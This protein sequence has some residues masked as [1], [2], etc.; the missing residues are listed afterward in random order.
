MGINGISL[1]IWNP[2]YYNK[3]I[4]TT[5]NSITF[6]KFKYPFLYNSS[7]LDEYIDVRISE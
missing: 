5:T 3:D 7:K 4:Y 1:M 2:I 6:D